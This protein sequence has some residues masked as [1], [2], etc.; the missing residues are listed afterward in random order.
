LHTKLIGILNVTP[1]SFYDGGKFIDA[2]SAI[3]KGLL[4]AREGADIIDIGGESTRPGSKGVG[5]DE[6][7]ERVI[8]VIKALSKQLDIPLSIDT[9]KAKV[10]QAALEAGASIVNDVSALR[11]DPEM[12]NVVV[13]YNARLVLM[14]SLGDPAT[15]QVDPHYDDV[16]GEINSFFAE[17]LEF[18]TSRGI[19]VSKIMLDPGIGF[20]KKL[21]HNLTIIRRLSDFKR[22]GVCI[23]VG[24]SNKSFIGLVLDAPV[25]KR[26]EGTIAAC[27]LAVANGADMLRVHDVAPVGRAVKLAETIIGNKTPDG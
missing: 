26:L 12:V 5:I 15:M 18:S 20:G 21:E 24:P 23:L 19:D 22:H 3:E 11:F 1:D 2:H 17:R 25:D 4:L 10:A 6:E 9:R 8:P 27:V 16:I 7:I 14:H 13:S